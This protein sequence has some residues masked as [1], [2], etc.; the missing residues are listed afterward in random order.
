MG[1]SLSDTVFTEE[2]KRIRK[3]AFENL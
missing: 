1:N 3:G 2:R